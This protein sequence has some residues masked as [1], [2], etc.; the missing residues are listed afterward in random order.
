[1]RD[2]AQVCLGW[3]C[4]LH[5]PILHVRHLIA[6]AIRSAADTL[7]GLDRDMSRS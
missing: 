4:T 6:V 7:D 2:L 3:I 1:M 5:V